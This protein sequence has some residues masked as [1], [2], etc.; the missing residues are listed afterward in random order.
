MGLKMKT[1]NRLKANS[2]GWIDELQPVLWS[3]RMTVTKPTGQTPFF[4]VY[5]AEAVLPTELKHGSPRVRAFDEPLQDDLRAE[6]LAL[7]K[8]TRCQATIRTARYQQGL[9]RY[10]SRHIRRRTLQVGDLVLR[11]ILSR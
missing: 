5:G 4:L 2:A 3:I 10:H 8:V 1:F 11:R 7:L 9:R 6:D